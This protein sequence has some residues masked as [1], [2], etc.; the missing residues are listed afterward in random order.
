M[1]WFRGWTEPKNVQI[2]FEDLRRYRTVAYACYDCE[3]KAVL[4]VHPSPNLLERLRD[5]SRRKTIIPFF[6]IICLFMN[7]VFSAAVFRSYL[8][9][10]FKSFKFPIDPNT[11]LVWSGYAGLVANILSIVIMR[12]FGKRIVYLISLASAILTLYALGMKL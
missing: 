2:E 12:L 3:K 1:Q 5:F 11:V 7:S 4:C 6:I 9:P 10:T 8:V